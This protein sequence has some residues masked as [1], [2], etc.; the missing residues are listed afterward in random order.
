MN[1]LNDLG[2]TPLHNS[3]QSNSNPGMVQT[4]IASGADVNARDPE[5]VV[6]GVAFGVTP[7]HLAVGLNENPAVVRALIGGGADVNARAGNSY[8]TPLH[9]VLVGD[10]ESDDPIDTVQALLD[11]G[12]QATVW[13]AFGHTPLHQVVI[14]NDLDLFLDDRLEAIRVGLARVLIEA[15]ADVNARTRGPVSPAET[16]L[17]W[18]DLDR[19]PEQ[20]PLAALLREH[21]GQR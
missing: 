18:I 8:H 7:L 16:P 12:A 11:G 10:V 9:Y 14:F 4:L 19:F 5:D 21:G 1:A 13:N 20:A 17:D 6:D 3:A 15:G 2:D